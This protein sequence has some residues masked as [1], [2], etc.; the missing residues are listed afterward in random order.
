MNNLKNFLLAGILLYLSFNAF[1][2]TIPYR[3]QANNTATNGYTLVWQDDFKGTSLDE[4]NNWVI[5]VNGDGGGNNELQYYRRENISVGNE[6]VSGKSCLIITAKLESFSGKVCTSGR[7]KTI[8]KMQFKHGRIDASI[9]L[10]HT[11]NG[12]W[13]AFWL[14]GG[15]YPLV[16]WPKCGEIDILE[17]GNT[18]GIN[19]GTQDKYYST[20]YHWG[21]SWNG[22]SYPNWGQAT[23]SSYGVQDDFHLYTL[24]WNDTYLETYL[25]LDKY[26]NATPLAH[27]LINGADVAGNA[28]HYFHKQFYVI[29]NLAI[30]G[31]FTGITGNSNIGKITALA[32]GSAKMYVDY[33]KVYQQGVTGEEYSGP[34]L[35]PNGINELSVQNQFKVY[36]NPTKNLINI[37]ADSEISRVTVITMSGQEV[38]SVSNTKSISTSGLS[39]GNY[40]IKIVDVN[41]KAETHQIT[42][43]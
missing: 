17:M 31:N 27:M 42:K 10:P 24:I 19:A 3:V 32:S 18:N 29:F 5:E 1:S 36:P 2:Q 22:G 16:G 25:D 35:V 21:E 34:V 23:T 38:M 39:S 14:M 7:M 41:G 43:Q 33:V 30:G 26:P 20:H 28:A 12:L 37:E 11:A 4:T 13:P 8:G 15:D 6:P 9:K 40:L